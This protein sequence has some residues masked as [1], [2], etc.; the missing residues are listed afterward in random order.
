MLKFKSMHRNVKLYTQT[1]CKIQKKNVKG[2]LIDHR[3]KVGRFSLAKVMDR[4]RNQLY[5]H[6]CGWDKK[7]DTFSDYRSEIYRFAKA[8]SISER[9]LTRKSMQK[10][11]IGDQIDVNPIAQCPEEGWVIATI[12]CKDAT[13][14]QVMV[15][16]FSQSRNRYYQYW[17]HLDDY[18]EADAPNA[19]THPARKNNNNNNNNINKIHT[20][21]K[22]GGGNKTRDVKNLEPGG[23]FDD[24]SSNMGSPVTQKSRLVC[25]M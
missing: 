16:Y 13:S 17:L 9:P 25:K 2:E 4:D 3:D 19:H 10:Y 6:Y 22:S 24:N 12:K 1:Y 7:Y 18:N 20:S 11:G 8:K 23:V 14:G 21:K 5:I 15:Q